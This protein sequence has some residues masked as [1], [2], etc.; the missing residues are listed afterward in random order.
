[1]STELPRHDAHASRDPTSA[2]PVVT[3]ERGGHAYLV[4]GIRVPSVTQTVGVLGSD[5]LASWGQRVTVEGVV[6]L[7]ELGIG[8]PANIDAVFGLLQAHA[9]TTGAKAAQ[10]RARGTVVHQAAERI[11]RGDP[12]AATDYPPEHAG[13]IEALLAATRRLRPAEWIGSEVV[14]GSREH[15]FGGTYDALIV[16]HAGRRIRLDWKSNP[17]VY[18]TA[19][20]QIQAYELAAR[21]CGEEPAD[22]LVIV[23]LADDGSYE[24]VRSQATFEDFL[25]VLAAYRA[26]KRLREAIGNA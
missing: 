13:Y 15:L 4:D 22:Y 3:F 26:I 18:E 8:I 5:G 10:A 16:D 9:S 21:E 17:R 6:R 2:R 19:H 7:W 24:F 1:M 25:S 11:A 20:L 14:V 23:R 12:F